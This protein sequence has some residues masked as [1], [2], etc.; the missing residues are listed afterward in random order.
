MKCARGW[1]TLSPFSSKRVN[2][3]PGRACDRLPRALSLWRIDL[4]SLPYGTVAPTD[5]VSLAL[6]LCSA[7]ALSPFLV[8]D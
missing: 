2:E 3:G 7:M 8:C 1:D 4:F 6:L 5:Q